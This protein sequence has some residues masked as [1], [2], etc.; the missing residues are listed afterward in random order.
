M[1]RYLR[2][3]RLCTD[4]SSPT[5]KQEYLHWKRTFDAFLVSV[6]E[7]TPDKLQTLINHVTPAVY[8]YIADAA[9]YDA[10]V[11][12]LKGLYVQSKNAS[13]VRFQLGSRRQE[14]G[15]SLDVFVQQLKALA[16]EIEFKQVTAEQY[17]SDL[18]TNAMIFKIIT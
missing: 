15:E 13:F 9:D 18:L 8:A 7:H 11:G 1:D 16:A 17:K 10:A 2:P 14:S 4:P 12:I 5:A 6:N 3:E